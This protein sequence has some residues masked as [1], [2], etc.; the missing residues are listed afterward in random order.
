MCN[1]SETTPAVG[2][3]ASGEIDNMISRFGKNPG[4]EY[5]DVAIFTVEVNMPRTVFAKTVRIVLPGFK[6]EVD[7][8]GK[9]FFPVIFW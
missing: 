8:R 9:M 1:A 4:S 6:G 2:V 5:T 7:G 3:D